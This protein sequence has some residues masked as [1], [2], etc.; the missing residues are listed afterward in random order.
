MEF[1]WG[2]GDSRLG[3]WNALGGHYVDA[4]PAYSL[5]ERHWGAQRSKEKD[6]SQPTSGS[7]QGYGVAKDRS[8]A[9]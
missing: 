6:K 5:M 9:G 8:R 1:L 2:R 4:N 3:D 7:R